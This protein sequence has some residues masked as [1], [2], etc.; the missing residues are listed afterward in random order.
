MGEFNPN[1]F[2]SGAGPENKA[3][4]FFEEIVF[5][6]R[7]KPNGQF[8]Y[9]SSAPGRKIIFLEKDQGVI[10]EEGQVYKVKIIKDT[11]PENPNNGKMI[12]R[13]VLDDDDAPLSGGSVGSGGAGKKFIAPLEVQPNAKSILVLETEIPM[14][15]RRGNRIPDNI[16]LKEYCLSK[17][18][19]KT[20]EGN[21][22]AVLNREP[23]LL[24]GYTAASKTSS[25]EYLAMITK[26]E[27]ARINLSG[28][29]DTSDLIGKYVPNDGSLESQ[30][31]SLL[32][33]LDSLSGES[34]IILS[35]A[36]QEGRSLTLF[37]S[38]KIAAIEKLKISDWRWQD[39][40]VPKAMKN[41]Y[42]LIL[43]EINLAE[44]QILE[45][46]NSLL[47]SSPSLVLTE[48]DGSRI[49][50]KGDVNL[51]SDFRIFA[52][53]NP[54]SYTGRNILS[55]A[56]KNRWASYEFVKS[57]TAA[58]Y[59]EMVNLKI[60]GE[61]PEV[62]M[63]GVTY[64]GKNNKVRFANLEQVPNLRSL[65]QK[66]TKFQE[67]LEKMAE[68]RGIG[69]DEKEPYIF[70]RRNLMEFVSDLNNRVI[71]DRATGKK[72]S[73]LDD[74]KRIILKCLEYKYLNQI[75]NSVDLQKVEDQLV[76]YGISATTWTHKFE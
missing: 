8:E 24:E 62:E 43:D 52:T 11:D 58:D 47:E 44:P 32:K 23:R 56:Y 30:F 54:A 68:S 37:E 60:Y 7:S 45:R 6:K 28:Q 25:I 18:T 46:L 2:E 63:E 1:N 73:I 26:N 10:P 3:E 12:G 15:N 53:M 42:W 40:A 4:N 34:K 66:I 20:I 64:K 9:R 13:I 19:L 17:K 41:G 51:H 71:V 74:P 5:E 14:N 38:Q 76:A 39:G 21:A 69:I 55:P 59:E 75:K 65:M 57:P 49:A 67:A 70:T 72:I 16:E 50:E 35:Q 22:L 48:F 33:N 27:V 36:K 61:Q 29:T 31:E